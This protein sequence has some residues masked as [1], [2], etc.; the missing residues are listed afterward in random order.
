MSLIRG[1][2]CPSSRGSPI[3]RKSSF[4]AIPAEIRGHVLPIPSRT[5]S[6]K[7]PSWGATPSGATY[8]F[9]VYYVGDFDLD[10]LYKDGY[11]ICR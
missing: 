8:L 10:V 3:P 1:K 11:G 6:V 7:S 9:F 2:A 5:L 4:D